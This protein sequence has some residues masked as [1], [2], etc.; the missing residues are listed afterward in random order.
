MNRKKVL[1]IVGVVLVSPVS[2]AFWGYGIHIPDVV[3]IPVI[4]AGAVIL[5]AMILRGEV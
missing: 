5:A 3:N 1:K 2:Y 4:A